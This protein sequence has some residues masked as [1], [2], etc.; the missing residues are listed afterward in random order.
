VRQRDLRG[1][2][3]A[4][5][6]GDTGDDLDRHARSAA[7]LG[8][9]SAATEHERVAA[10]EPYD[11]ASHERLANQQRVDCVLRQRVPRAALCH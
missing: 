2:R 7:R 9:F 10:L 11:V 6:R 8:L 5:R 4:E 3:R 1:G